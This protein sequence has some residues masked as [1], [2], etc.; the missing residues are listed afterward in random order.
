MARA[1]RMS[2]QEFRNKHTGEAGTV[3]LFNG[4]PNHTGKPSCSLYEDNEGCSVHPARPLACR[5]FPL[6]RQIQN[7]KAQYIH[8]GSVFPCLKE[9]PEVLELPLLTVEEYLI[10]QE[11]HAFEQAQDEYLEV[12][13]NLAD[14]SFELLLDTGLAESCDTQ[15]LASWRKLGT[16]NVTDLAKQIP[17]E[18][19]DHLMIPDLEGQ[20]DNVPDFVQVHQETLNTKIQEL[21]ENLSSFD[22]VRE[23][24]VL[25]MALAL[26][27]AH[28]IGA[29]VKGLS[30][31][32]IESAKSYGAKE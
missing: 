9:C 24:A 7:G 2:S 19:L 17:A 6:G 28:A 16:Q 20:P 3:L 26:F 30:E 23:S 12:M 5:L 13:Q 21:S 1:N 32:W 25:I 14:L 8:E 15:T 29:D 18:W 31:H 10:G 22:T 4:T 11:T 27:L